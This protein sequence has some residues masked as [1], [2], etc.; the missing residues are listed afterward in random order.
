MRG[1]IIIWLDKP[2]KIFLQM[3]LHSEVSINHIPLFVVFFFFSLFFIQK[4]N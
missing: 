1:G 4:K 2:M 3:I